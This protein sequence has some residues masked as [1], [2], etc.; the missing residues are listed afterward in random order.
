LQ[1]KPEIVA[2]VRKQVMDAVK[3]KPDFIKAAEPGGDE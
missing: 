1:D 3:N 2:D